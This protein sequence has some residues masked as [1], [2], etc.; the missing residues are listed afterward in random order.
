MYV[1]RHLYMYVYTYTYY[2]LQCIYTCVCTYAY[3]YT[4]TLIYMDIYV[5]MYIHKDSYCTHTYVWCYVKQC[6]TM[7]LEVCRGTVSCILLSI[8]QALQYTM[9]IFGFPSL[10][11]LRWY[12]RQIT[13]LIYTII[14]LYYFSVFQYHNNN[15]T[16]ISVI[17]ILLTV[18][19]S[20][21]V[22]PLLAYN[23]SNLGVILLL[24]NSFL[25]FLVYILTHCLWLT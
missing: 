20:L 18:I 11:S 3:M 4:C 23:M 9:L 14:N 12:L 22:S 15:T 25:A 7:I 17:N 13:W 2:I 1:G 24:F 21:R 16:N 19:V 6:C 10:C 5:Y 8:L